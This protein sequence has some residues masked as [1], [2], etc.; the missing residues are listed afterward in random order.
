MSA[1]IYKK[2]RDGSE[3]VVMGRVILKEKPT[4]KRAS[5]SDWTFSIEVLRLRE[6]EKL[7]RHRHGAMI[8][9]P[10]DTDDRCICLDYIRAAA[11][12][13]APEDIKSWSKKW[14]PWAT[15]VEVESFVI[16]ANNRRKMMK[17]DGVARLL[18]VTLEERNLI[19]LNTIGACDVPRHERK[20]LAK[21]HKREKDRERQAKLREARGCKDRKS[22]AATTISTQ[23][24]WEAEGVSRAT[25]YRKRRE[26]EQ[27]RV[28]IN[29]I[30]DTFVSLPSEATIL[31]HFGRC[32]AEL[33]IAGLGDH[34][35]AELQEAEPHGNEDAKSQ[36]AA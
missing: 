33:E 11:L 5:R 8:P 30:G 14:A 25:W 4:R 36:R 28:V 2:H 1:A 10:E 3:S 24:P 31:M 16:E 20:K 17:S 35:P 12:S 26:T 6:I 9:D 7:I 21:E 23:K 22:H 19:K 27:S 34:S 18:K 13:N 15:A 29:R 32:E